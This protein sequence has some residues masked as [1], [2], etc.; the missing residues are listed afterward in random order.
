MRVSQHNAWRFGRGFTAVLVVDAIVIAGLFYA[1]GSGGVYSFLYSSP[2]AATVTSTS[3][4]ALVS[5]TSGAPA[6]S[7]STASTNATS[8]SSVAYTIGVATSP[9]LGTYLVDGAGFTLYYFVP[10]QVGN[11]TSPPV[12]HCTATL[13]CIQVWP[14]FYAPSI[15]VPASLNASAFTTFTRADGSNQTAY[16]GHPLYLYLGDS[17]PGQTNGN[18]ININGGY[19]YVV[20]ASA[21]AT[22]KSLA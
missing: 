5:S 2:H 6:N 20:P 4:T 7:T 1:V 9:T 22:F 11:A 15:V 16:L 18:A 17:S 3:T 21:G 13:S 14:V 12:S 19:W 10:D 8:T